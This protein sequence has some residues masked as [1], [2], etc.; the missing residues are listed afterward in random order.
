MSIIGLKIHGHWCIEGWSL[1]GHE[2]MRK[3]NREI[4][5]WSMREGGKGESK[6]QEGKVGLLHMKEMKY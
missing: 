1:I 3:V 2:K 5:R 4:E 6:R